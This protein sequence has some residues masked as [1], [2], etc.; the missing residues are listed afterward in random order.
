MITL[1]FRIEGATEKYIV[2][3]DI[4]S[5]ASGQV[6]AATARVGGAKVALKVLEYSSI[7][8][9]RQEYRILESLRGGP[10]SVI[11]VIERFFLPKL[12][13]IGFHRVMVL[14]FPLMDG[15][16]RDFLKAHEGPLETPLIRSLARDLLSGVAHLASH[17]VA[18]NDL[19]PR[20]ILM[21]GT[22]AVITD[23][24]SATTA[25]RT[26]APQ[27]FVVGTFSYISPEVLLEGQL[28]LC[29]SS[30]CV[31]PST[32]AISQHPTCGQLA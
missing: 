19:K 4:G 1:K 5:G 13:V 32:H 17:Y 3:E 28:G 11:S 10:E 12:P 18:H 20:N 16:L 24:G 27:R 30:R 14:A 15:T 25:R 21:R 2:E 29:K 7:R 26:R 23:F 6:V 31:M 8:T 9:S 22:R